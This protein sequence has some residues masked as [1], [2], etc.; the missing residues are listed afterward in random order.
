MLGINLKI[1]KNMNTDLTNRIVE[2]I[3][4]DTNYAIIIN[5]GYGIGKTHYIKN[6]LFPLIK[7]KSIPNSTIDEKFNPIPISLFGV[8]SIEDIQNQ[9]LLELYPI[10]KSKGL[11]IA[12]GLGKSLIKHLAGVDLSTMFSDTEIS[13]SDLFDYSKVLLCIDDIDRKSKELQLPEVFGYVNN[14]VENY[15]AKIILIAN[16][17]ELRKEINTETDRDYYSILKEKVIGISVNFKSNVSKIYDEIIEEK[18]KVL[19]EAYYTFLLDH[20]VLIVQ[21]VELNSGN[22]RNLLFFLEHFK[23]IYKSLQEC[24][25]VEEKY[26]D[27]KTDIVNNILDFALPIAIEYKMG[28]LNP[29]NFEDIQ[30]I[31]IGTSFDFMRFM[32]KKEAI[33][34]PKTFIDEYKQKYISSNHDKLMYFDS[35][36]KYITGTSSLNI[37][38]LSK[39]I[40]LI[41]KFEDNTIPEREKTLTKLNYW[42]CI[43]LTNS[44]YRFQTKKLLESVDKGEF[45][46]D[47]YPTIFH[48]VTRF[49]NLLNYNINNLKKR[50]K[51]GIRSG[52]IKYKYVNN[53]HFKLS[54]DKSSEFYS[55][56][57]EIVDFC[58]EINNSIQRE[59]EEKKVN[60][61]FEMFSHNFDEF[62]EKIQETNNDFLFSPYLSTFNFNKTWRIINKLS[63]LQTINLAFYFSYRY[64]L[65]IFEGLYPE[66]EFLIALKE[67]VTEKYEK[68][69]TTKMVKIALN[70]LNKKINESINNFPQKPNA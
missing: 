11:K 58:D 54:I 33:E 69:G 62:I 6:Q 53:L 38:E 56:L 1:K 67:K 29:G 4:L 60:D 10:L 27:I 45:S 66:K 64:K 17:D 9:I 47:Q 40:S 63:N 19:Y 34:T 59:I 22:L 18:Y 57:K 46:L 2:Y 32:G 15:N 13:S 23:I 51:K 16:E 70:F 31:Y 24:I 39:E 49:D 20:K 41:Y 52:R 42:G 30:N 48:Y 5:G 26:K 35:I 3:E 43:D 61:V 65:N 44:D 50:F 28:K 25:F 36:F 7:K 8:N 21:S 55:D 68:K 37:E 14:L 12:A